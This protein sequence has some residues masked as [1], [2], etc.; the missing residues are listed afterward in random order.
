VGGKNAT[1]LVRY[2][3]EK[4]TMVTYGGMSRQPVI[5]PT[6]ALIFNEVKILG[7]WNTQWNFENKASKEDHHIQ[8]CHRIASK[9][10]SVA[11][12]SRRR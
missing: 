12:E 4:G 11:L 9:F 1:E 5:I 2:L 10:D 8:L 6:G 3:R 7:Y